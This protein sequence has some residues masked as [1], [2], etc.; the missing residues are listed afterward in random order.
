MLELGDV[1]QRSFASDPK[2]LAF[3]L[4]RYHFVA[5]MIQGKER[6]LEVGCGDGT[7]AMLVLP[8]VRSLLCTDVDLT[9]METS[10]H[11]SKLCW[12][13]HDMTI[14]PLKDEGGLFDA[15]YSVDVLEHIAP[16][17]REHFFLTN[18]V[19][20]MKSDGV[21]VCGMPSLES[22]PYASYWSKQRHVNCKT[23]DGLRDLLQG[24]FANVFL[25]GMNDCTLHVGFG[26]MCHYRFAVCV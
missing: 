19:T 15:V 4:A 5:R 24:Y 17:F 16:D 13:R 23:E 20:S 25:F 1:Y 3:V 14:E 12:R 2:H 6:V 10:P 9:S 11:R 7:G 26:P 22:Q 21:F 18:I 8:Q